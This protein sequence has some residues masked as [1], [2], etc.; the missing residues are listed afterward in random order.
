MKY[1]K[2][3]SEIKNNDIIKPIIRVIVTKTLKQL[4]T[5]GI[6]SFIEGFICIVMP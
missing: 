3:L 6:D 4:P 2:E 1:F 5:F